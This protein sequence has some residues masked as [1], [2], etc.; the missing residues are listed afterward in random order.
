MESEFM[1]EG[2]DL[3]HLRVFYMAARLKKFLKVAQ[4]LNIDASAVTRHIQALEQQLNCQLIE[5]GGRSGLA[6]TEK[7]E[8]ILPVIREIFE[9][10][11]KITPIL[12]QTEK[13]IQGPI[14]IALHT[15]YAFNVILPLLVDFAEMYPLI[16]LDIMS[17]TT[18]ESL[19]INLREADV[20]I[21]PFLGVDPNLIQRCLFTYKLGLFA[22]Q[23]YVEK[24][25]SPER[26]EDLHNHRLIAAN[27]RQLGPYSRINWHLTL[28]S[29]KP[30]TPY[31]K[32]D[33]NLT[34]YLFMKKGLGIASFSPS[35]L[36][37]KK[38]KLVSILP[39]VSG[40]TPDVLF[41]CASHFEK[42]KKI[43][44]LYEFLEERIKKVLPYK[45]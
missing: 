11:S 35:F 30:I 19:D 13:S 14:R 17:I 22:S 25:G 3:E 10:V 24:F 27:I 36:D 4:A 38:D 43:N 20:L 41:A 12:S 45:K 18:N 44:V 2:L 42:S 32:V 31:A 40:P 34:A 6:L 29:H 28:T 39:E 16:N 37:L 8:A 9:S 7:G 5:R 1:I 26:V 23:T 15:G 33:N 21:G